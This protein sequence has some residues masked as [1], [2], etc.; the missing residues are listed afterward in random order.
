MKIEGLHKEV[1]VVVFIVY[2]F[3]FSGD[4]V[5]QTN[6]RNNFLVDCVI[7]QNS[8]NVSVDHKFFQCDGIYFE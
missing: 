4:H 6:N 7:C 1:V 5:L 8:L 3:V 2:I